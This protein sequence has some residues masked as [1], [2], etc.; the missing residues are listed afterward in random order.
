MSQQLSFELLFEHFSAVSATS[1]W[2]L[3]ENPPSHLP[4]ANP[5]IHIISNRIDVV[6]L[7]K[8]H[9][10]E[11]SYSDFDFSTIPLT[12]YQYIFF[13]ISK[14]KALAHYVINSAYQLLQDK[15]K[16]IISGAKQEGIKG[17]IERSSKLYTKLETLKADKQHWAAILERNEPII[18][19]LADKNY[20]VLRSI[21]TAQE[22]F[23]AFD[24]FSKPGVFGWDK[25]DAGSLLLIE[26]LQDIY[27]QSP[28][29]NNV[30]DIGCGY[31]YLSICCAVLFNTPVVACDNNAAAISACRRN[32]AQLNAAHQVIAT[33][34]TQGIIEKFSLIVCNPPFHSGFEVEN[35]LT[36][37]FLKGAKE[38]LAPGGMALFV[39]NLHIPLERKARNYFN[40][41]QTISDNQHFKV[42]KL[43]NH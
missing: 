31:G 29:P 37:Q 4:P 5:L 36:D 22:R 2:I 43:E 34:C 23:P 38:R 33:N 25:V 13:R 7:M 39:V 32:L 12:R 24:F 18:Q 8:A 27:Q 15:G 14:E 20:P 21:N 41:I 17:Y 42:I 35:N 30:L 11:A 19:P 6:A 16:L 26:L 40:H 9:G 28:A 1:L 3:D 10:F